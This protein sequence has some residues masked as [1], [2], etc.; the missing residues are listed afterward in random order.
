MCNKKLK[1]ETKMWQSNEF[2]H[3]EC[4]K[5]NY[6]THSFARHTHEGFAIGV[7]ERGVEVFNYRGKL[8]R[9]EKGE[10]ILINP[11]EVHDGSGANKDGWG[12]RIFY[13]DA[14]ILHRAAM[15]IAEKRVDLPTFKNP[16]VKNKVI[17]DKLLYLHR[18]L[19]TS[20]STLERESLI[21][22]TFADLITAEAQDAP[23]IK[24]FDGEPKAVSRA[25]TYLEENYMENVSLAELSAFSYLSQFHL[26]RVFKKHTGFSPHAYLEQIRINHAKELIK[27]GLN[28]I[29]TAYELGFVDQSH[30][31][32]TFKKYAGMTPGQYS[33][34][35]QKIANH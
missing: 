22:T 1:D 29:D 21:M 6:V 34:S 9:A 19:E 3:L 2:G 16:V 30:L 31:N 17:S 7:V 26:I 8:N 11:A 27:S 14:K 5:A 25:K 15:E 23:P 18:R 28:L 13:A 32:K 4:L 12:F 35:Y 20:V 10:I 24:N 33:A